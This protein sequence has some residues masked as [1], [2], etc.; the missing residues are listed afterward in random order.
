MSKS[1]GNVINPLE[2]LDKYGADALRM[3]LISGAGA[4]SDQNYSESK[5]IGYRNFANKI[6]N[7]ARFVKEFESTESKESTS[8]GYKD[9]IKTTTDLVTKKI[10]NYK[11][12]NAAEI[13][14]KRFWGNFCDMDIEFAKKGWLS[15]KEMLWGLETYLKL[16]H[17]FVP[18]VTEAV[19]KELGND[20][21]LIGETWPS[22]SNA[23]AK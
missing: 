7:A 15:K 14:Y 2:V 5:V 21:L 6:W 1:K 19:W 11:L 3:S 8:I 17:P 22:I 18:F 4:G 20:T 23:K 12:N 16:L 9:R 10:N 13:A